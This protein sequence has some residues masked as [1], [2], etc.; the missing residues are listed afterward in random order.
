MKL[1]KREKPVE[2]ETP[3]EIETIEK[4]EDGIVKVEARNIKQYLVD[5]Y[6]RAQKLVELNKRQSE[7]LDEAEETKYKYDAALV[8]LDEYSDRL[9]RYENEID[10]LNKTI[11][12]Q[13]EKTK[14]AMEQVN[15]LKI[16]MHHME[17]RQAAESM[18]GWCIDAVKNTETNRAGNIPKSEIIEVLENV[19]NCCIGDAR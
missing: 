7:Q 6:E 13:K 2:V 5:E 18:R 17:S 16:T 1:F 8:T 3:L 14:V 9:K 11:D 12:E 15:S 19:E 4:P 10:N